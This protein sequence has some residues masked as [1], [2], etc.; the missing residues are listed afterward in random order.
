MDEGVDFS[1]LTIERLTAE[2][3]IARSTFYVYFEDRA[4]L[5]RAWI[6]ALS[7]ESRAAAEALWQLAPPFG[8][9]ELR[10]NVERVIADYR[11]VVPM[12]SAASRAAAVDPSAAPAI[13]RLMAANVE[14]LR[15][16]IV[17]GQTQGFIDEEL[18]PTETATWLT[19]M[20]VTMYDNRLPEADEEE[21]TAMVDSHARILWRVLYAPA[22]RTT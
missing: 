1:E 20:A 15:R 21:F 14:G 19:W 10:A 5:I 3:A 7:S 4:A 6:A 8:P 2:A 11:R 16:H 13:R 17:T 12:M 18:D 9:D 22:L